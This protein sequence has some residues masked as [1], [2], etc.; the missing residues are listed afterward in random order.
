MFLGKTEK[1]KQLNHTF[2]DYDEFTNDF[3]GFPLSPTLPDYDDLTGQS[4]E[5]V[6]DSKL[7]VFRLI[8]IGYHF[9]PDSCD[10]VPSIVY[11]N[12]HSG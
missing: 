8:I 2:S 5:I 11:H 4:Y 7:K 3:L 6:P 9:S 12:T 10:N 1:F